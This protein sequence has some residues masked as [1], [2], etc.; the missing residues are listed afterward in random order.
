M[1]S[2]FDFKLIMYRSAKDK[3]EKV[4]LNI[5]IKDLENMGFLKSPRIPFLY[6]CD[7]RNFNCIS[8]NKNFLKTLHENSI[9]N[10]N[11]K[12]LIHQDLIYRDYLPR[13]F[14]SYLPSNSTGDN[15]ELYNLSKRCL[16]NFNKITLD[17]L[18]GNK[19]DRFDWFV[20][21]D[22][23]LNFLIKMENTEFVIDSN[24]KTINSK[25]YFQDKLQFISLSNK[26]VKN[27]FLNINL[28]SS[29]IYIFE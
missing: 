5:P 26:E 2:V 19:I 28:N 15:T 27:I 7:S 25:I 18:T 4:D 8:S 12:V 23:S 3:D 21:D 1:R 16:N 9:K 22:E 24:I 6:L 13:C 20:Y 29:V 10:N 14:T 17:P 11:Y